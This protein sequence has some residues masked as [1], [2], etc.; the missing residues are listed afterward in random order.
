MRKLIFSLVAVA[1]IATT[2]SAQSH[3]EIWPLKDNTLFQDNTGSLS[4]G[5]GIYFFAG[6][7]NNGGIRRGLLAFDIA[8]NVPSG[9]RIDS[10]ILTL[11]MSRT[12]AGAGQQTFTLHKA[13]ANW[14]EGSSNAGGEEGGGSPATTGDAT[15]RHRFFNTAFWTTPGGDFSQSASAGR[16]VDGIAFYT[17]GPTPELTADVQSWLDNPGSNFGWVMLGDESA[18]L[19]AKRFD[20]RDNSAAANRPK[21]TVY[22]QTSNSIE[23]ETAPSSMTTLLRQNTPNPFQSQTQIRFTL[24]HSEHANLSV[25]SIAGQKVAA[26][27]NQSLPGGEHTAVFDGSN[28]APGIYFYQLTTT[29]GKRTQK[30]LLMR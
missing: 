22:F 6:K 24:N 29:A 1:L 17:W 21:L 12:N 19:T 10:V 28:L 4:N 14:G 9:A 16:V 23:N 7:I 26:L 3:A 15:W 30:M 5:A 20:S 25:Y 27:I 8:A 13:L 18:S 2:V 11:R